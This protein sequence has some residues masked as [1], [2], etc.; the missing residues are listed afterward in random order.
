MTMAG[1]CAAAPV[2]GLPSLRT[3]PPTNLRL[4]GFLHC[5]S[6]PRSP[7]GALLGWTQGAKKQTTTPLAVARLNR[8]LFLL[9]SYSCS[10][11]TCEEMGMEVI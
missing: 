5:S 9:C 4:G 7:G 8:G 6:A 1:S 10:A 3:P 11:D 2:A